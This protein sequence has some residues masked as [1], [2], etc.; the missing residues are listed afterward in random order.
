MDGT[1]NLDENLLCH[2]FRIFSALNNRYGS[3][4]NTILVGI[5][6]EFKS[7]LI[8]TAK[9]LYQLKFIQGSGAV[10]FDAV[11]YENI[12]GKNEAMR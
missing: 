11:T 2:I 4:K 9:T 12:G 7:G 8:F 1:K 6:Q 10:G 3:I 5:Y